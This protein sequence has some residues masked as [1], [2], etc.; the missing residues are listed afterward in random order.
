MCVWGGVV[1]PGWFSIILSLIWSLENYKRHGIHQ[2]RNTYSDKKLIINRISCWI[3]MLYFGC[4][5][6]IIICGA[7][8]IQTSGGETLDVL[9]QG[10]VHIKGGSDRQIPT[11]VAIGRAVHQTSKE[12]SVIPARCPTIQLNLDTVSLEIVSDPKGWGLAP[13][14]CPHFR[15]QSQSQHVH[16]TSDTVVADDSFSLSPSWFWWVC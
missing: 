1:S 10:L 2:N 6:W 13:I 16:C 7:L 9:S 5:P 11:W 3:G 15:C 8:G 12:F 4:S 14:S